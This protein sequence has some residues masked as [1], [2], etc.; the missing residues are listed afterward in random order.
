MS[1]VDFYLDTGKWV[2]KSNIHTRVEFS[3]SLFDTSYLVLRPVSNA[4]I[5]LILAL[6]WAVAAQL[7]R[8][9]FLLASSNKS[10]AR[11]IAGITTSPHF[12]PQL[13]VMWC[14]TSLIPKIVNIAKMSPEIC[15]N[16][17]VKQRVLRTCSIAS[18]KLLTGRITTIVNLARV[19]SQHS[20]VFWPPPLAQ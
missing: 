3:F 5:G 6:Q 11:S 20:F 14:D 19:F 10:E 2:N 12:H 1:H 13:D 9:W 8:G 15:T 17:Y 18:L 16:S 4:Q 7:S